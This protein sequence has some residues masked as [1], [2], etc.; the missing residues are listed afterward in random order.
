M[1]N[2][3]TVIKP[4][5]IQSPNVWPYVINR[6]ET[7]EALAP[8]PGCIMFVGDSITQRNEWCEMLENTNI[9]NRGI[10][11][12]RISWLNERMNN[13]VANKPSKIFVKIGINDI[14]DGKPV[15]QMIEEYTV[16][17]EGLKVC[18]NCEVFVQSCL[19]VNNTE[20]NHPINNE[21]VQVFNV[22][23]KALAENYGFEF[24]NLYDVF[25]TEKNELNSE[26][27]RDGVHLNG[28]GYLNW[29][30]QIEQLI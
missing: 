30:K 18:E 20:Y 12:D 10:D 17:L 9:I 5:Y 6:R 8:K 25:V 2:E 28:K 26:Y 1:S 14:M 24:I 19:P 3:T 4:E 27:T 21:Q 15:E 11:S 23:L 22:Q 16:I 29:K 7:F 13:L